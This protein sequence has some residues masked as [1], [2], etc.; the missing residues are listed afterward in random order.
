MGM[1]AVRDDPVTREDA[2]AILESEFG[3]AG[4]D[5]YLLPLVP[6][7]E[8]A[9][10]DGEPRTAELRLLYEFALHHVAELDREAEGLDVLTVDQVNAFLGRFVDKAPRTGQLRRLRMF[11]IPL[12]F[13]HSDPDVNERRRTTL[14]SYC[15][16]IGAAAV[17]QYPYGLHERFSSPEKALMLDLVEAFR[18]AD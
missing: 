10:A 16:D 6:L 9:W 14:L 13:D 11:S 1:P 18:P 7:I 3:V 5:I 15:L 8:M 12:I 17:R 4:T 2:C